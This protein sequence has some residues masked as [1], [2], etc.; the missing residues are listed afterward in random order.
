MQV[1][2]CIDE[3]NIGHGSVLSR[4]GPSLA[5]VAKTPIE[6]EADASSFFDRAAAAAKKYRFNP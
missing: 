5:K 1:E 4:Q 2:V 6:I 3:R